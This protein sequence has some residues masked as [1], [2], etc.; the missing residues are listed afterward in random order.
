MTQV[1]VRASR[2]CPVCGEEKTISEFHASNRRAGCS[3]GDG[4]Y[5]QSKCK[6]CQVDDKRNTRVRNRAF[7]DTEKLKSSC[8]DCGYAE[9]AFALDFHHI[10]KKGFS[11]G[12]GFALQTSL[13][14]LAEEI[15]ACVVL[16]AICHRK[17]HHAEGRS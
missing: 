15:K 14:V 10:G 8:V 7:L 17:R 9:Y 4:T 12:S 2:L 3:V 11:F 1:V 13:A 5:V 16:C 6:A